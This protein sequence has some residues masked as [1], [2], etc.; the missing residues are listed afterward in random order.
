LQRSN[1]AGT[2]DRLDQFGDEAG[3]QLRG[4]KAVA[5][6]RDL[7]QGELPQR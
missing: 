6:D 7:E 5:D 2:G 1:G 3:N 4:D